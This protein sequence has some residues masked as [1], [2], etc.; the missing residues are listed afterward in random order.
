MLNTE[1]HAQGKMSTGT[2]VHDLHIYSM[3]YYVY[4][5]T[6]HSHAGYGIPTVGGVTWSSQTF[7]TSVRMRIRRSTKVE[8]RDG[9]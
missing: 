4:I 3:I 5:Y 7:I 6:L 8:N 9:G 2:F 1:Q